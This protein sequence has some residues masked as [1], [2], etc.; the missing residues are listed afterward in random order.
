[1]LHATT[2]ALIDKLHEMTLSGDIHWED[3]VEREQTSHVS[4]GYRVT[5]RADEH[6][7]ML[8][9]A[10]GRD[11]ETVS[12]GLLLS[13]TRADGRTYADIVDEIIVAALGRN[14]GKDFAIAKLMGGMGRLTSASQSADDEPSAALAA[15]DSLVEATDVAVA[16]LV[17]VDEDAIPVEAVE[18][19][20]FLVDAPP[21]QGPDQPAASVQPESWGSWTQPETLV[22]ADQPAQDAASEAPIGAPEP[23]GWGFA[24]A[25]PEA[26]RRSEDWSVWNAAPETVPEAATETTNEPVAVS[27]VEPD[28]SSGTIADHVSNTDGGL[29]ADS[30]PA[31]Q[32]D[33]A[34]DVAVDM[35]SDSD[36]QFGGADSEQAT[37]AIAEESGDAPL[38]EHNAGWPAHDAEAAAETPHGVPDE[39][40]VAAES[41][42]TPEPAA[43]L[44]P[45]EP[46]WPSWTS[47]WVAEPQ[48]AVQ[49][50]TTELPASAS[51]DEIADSAST[52]AT[53]EFAP[54]PEVTEPEVTAAHEPIVVGTAEHSG[55]DFAS[56]EPEISGSEAAEPEASQADAVELESAEPVATEFAAVE[57]VSVVAS[58]DIVEE[59]ETS[60]EAGALFDTPDNA[61]IE[62][63]TVD[64][65]DGDA[66]LPDTR[67]ADPIDVAVQDADADVTTD[68]PLAADNSAAE[69][70][71]VVGAAL[72]EQ[73]EPEPEAPDVQLAGPGSDTPEASEAGGPESGMAEPEP[74]TAD[75]GAA[76]QRTIYRYNPWM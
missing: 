32:A 59:G 38:P 44:T 14:R 49:P 52:P 6:A 29:G 13:A 45:A 41:E 5:L 21:E 53:F 15:D 40:F 7:L 39:P 2:K 9:D 17:D 64:Q 34:I 19:P 47:T 23:Q 73:R 56:V 57:P 16:P 62:V 70:P 1:M 25:T 58:P 61:E 50:E 67:I 37:E 75:A 4:E 31:E 28:V 42:P 20:G 8:F 72:D 63:Q 26:Q 66:G 74:A 68:E 11:L 54:E 46:A 30:G 65:D 22:V 35:S 76:P 33:P 55:H 43:E 3:D 10:G 69:P 48:P 24:A 27:L 12:R 36:A 18:V 71:L 60:A 51:A